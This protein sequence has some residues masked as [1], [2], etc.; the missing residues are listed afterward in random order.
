VETRTNT[1]GRRRVGERR[2]RAA[3]NHSEEAEAGGRA[4]EPNAADSTCGEGVRE[5]V[6]MAEAYREAVAVQLL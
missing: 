6:D 4:D 5:R 2:R 3:A 1:R